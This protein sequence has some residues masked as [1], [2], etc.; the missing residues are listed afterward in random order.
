M[1]ELAEEALR[2]AVMTRIARGV[3]IR[4]AKGFEALVEQLQ[5]ALT[6]AF[7][8]ATRRGI[9]VALDRLR[10]LGDGKFTAADGETILRALERE[11]GAEALA[12][13]MREPVVNL[14]DSL[15]RL[16]LAE[17]GTAV[18][19]NLSFMRADQDALEVLSRVNQFWVGDLWDTGPR[20][21]IKGLLTEYFTTGLT[22]ESL[23]RRLAEDFAGVSENSLHHW[24]SVAN[25]LATRT[26]EIGRVSGYEKSGIR[27]VKIKALLDDRT[28]T[29]C[30]HL[31]G[32]V[33]TVESLRSQAETWMEASSRGNRVAAFAAWPFHG[34]DQ[35]LS[36]TPT[37]DLQG[38]G[39]PPYHHGNCRT[40]T[41]AYFGDA[42]GD[43]GRWR[44]AAL[45]REALSRSEVGK[46]VAQAKSANWPSD[47]V[48][49]GHFGKHKVAIGVA[50]Q[51]DY[52]QSAVDLIRSGG[53]DVY[54]S[55]RRGKLQAVFAKERQRTRSTGAIEDGFVVTAVDLEE[56]KIVSHHFRRKIENQT[57]EVAAKKQ[58]GRGVMKWLTW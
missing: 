32:R 40:I 54:L 18:G 31:H 35:D 52:N 11:V 39:M 2:A 26:R 55:V 10:D 34:D 42:P 6:G 14:S 36:Q 47:K 9:A 46:V 13:T 5:K 41:V 20:D 51:A 16:G 27:Q 48:A 37:R 15:Y 4:D 43:V 33:L 3:I 19:A 29:V 7:T 30:R 49:R 12:A 56:N 50:S 21:K 58:P 25:S 17:V 23:A 57:D 38:I 44:R 22:R 8:E 1:I 24:R 28:T 53:R 45:D